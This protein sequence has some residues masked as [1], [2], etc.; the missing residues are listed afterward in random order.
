MSESDGEKEKREYS[1]ISQESADIKALKWLRL[2]AIQFKSTK[3]RSPNK[4]AEGDSGAP[5]AHR[6][7]KSRLDNDP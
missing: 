6:Y 5:Y 4:V 1:S 7:Y 3:Y 2:T